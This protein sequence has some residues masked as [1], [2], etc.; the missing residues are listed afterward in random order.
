MSQ[1]QPGTLSWALGF[2]TPTG[3]AAWAAALGLAAYLWIRPA[4]SSSASSRGSGSGTA[5][6]DYGSG[7]HSEG[8]IGRG[9]SSYEQMP[10]GEREEGSGAPRQQ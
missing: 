5:G 4:G 2:R 8:G 10:L 6:G 1:Q 7:P 3:K 9:R